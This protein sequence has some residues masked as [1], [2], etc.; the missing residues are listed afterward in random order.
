M[1][2]QTIGNYRIIKRIGTGATATVFM[3]E[4]TGMARKAAIKILHP[5]LST[6]EKSLERFRREAQAIAALNHENIVRIYDFAIEKEHSFIIFE[7]IE[8][9][10]LK[11]FMNNVPDFPIELGVPF[12]FEVCRALK[13]AHDLNIVHRDIKPENILVTSDGK[14]KLTDFGVARL[15]EMENMT[16]T[17]ALIGSPNYMSP[18]QVE[19]MDIDVTSDVFSI[20]VL[21]YYLMTR[22]APFEARTHAKIIRNILAGEYIPPQHLNLRVNTLASK[23]IERCLKKHARDRYPSVV[24]LMESL[25]DLN[26]SFGFGSPDKE[27]RQYVA[28]K[29]TWAADYENRLVKHLL[30]SARRE[31]AGKNRARALAAIN[32]VLTMDKGNREAFRLYKRAFRKRRAGR[33]AVIISAMALGVMAVMLLIP[34]RIK[35]DPV[36]APSMEAGDTA[37]V[38]E[39]PLEMLP[40]EEPGKKQVSKKV[41][42]PVI[43]TAVMRKDMPEDTLDKAAEGTEAALKDSHVV[44]IGERD[45]LG[46]R[47]YG[48]LKIYTKEWA[49]I[50]IDDE[51]KGKAPFTGELILTAGPHELKLLNTYCHDLKDSIFIFADSVIEK[52]YK[53]VRKAQ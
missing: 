31:L 25:M 17:G 1:I 41:I 26:R 6:D 45:A 9:Y 48:T 36:S 14:I 40:A 8:G 50:Y 30:D 16:L 3:G 24:P 51:Y 33:W 23:I 32:H 15:M 10:T 18:E 20:G 34:T 21:F 29:E 13:A 43:K 42:K 28:Q 7:Y 49:K 35:Q 5:H 46:K 37:V 19:G 22:K 52:R 47:K 2:G 44:L 38:A 27:I 11:D 12:I 39:K 53:L 4:H